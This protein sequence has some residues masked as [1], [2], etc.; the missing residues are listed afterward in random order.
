MGIERI[1]I[2]EENAQG[3]TFLHDTLAANGYDVEA[4]A[5]GDAA[6]SAFMKKDFDLILVSESLPGLSGHRIL[7]RVK[8]LD[9]S[10]PVVLLTNAGSGEGVV[11]ALKAGAEDCFIR[12]FDLERLKMLLKKILHR[13]RILQENDYLRGEFR[14]DEGP[15]VLVGE[16]DP[17]RRAVLTARELADSDE[18]V[19]LKG[20]GGTGKEMLARVIHFEGSRASGPFVKVKCSGLPESL[21][22]SEFFGHERGAFSGAHRKREGRF[23]LAH[24][25]TLVLDGLGDIPVSL[26]AKLLEFLEEGRFHRMGGRRVI[27]VNVRVVGLT[28]RDLAREAEAGSFRRDLYQ[29]IARHSVQLPPLRDRADDV[30]LLVSHFVN[31][32]RQANDSQVRGVS[33]EAMEM[34]SHYAWPGN[35]RELRNLVQRLMVLNAGEE[36]TP[37]QLPPE[38]TGSL[39]GR[40]DPFSALVGMSVHEVER[41]MILKTLEETGN[42]KTAAAKILGLTARTLHNKLKLYREQGIIAKDAYRPIRRRPEPR[43]I[44]AVRQFS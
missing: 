26:Q 40:G 33:P 3:R 1:L 31:R 25:G 27:E 22:E 5:E 2:A 6:L 7:E 32:F 9:A 19:V 10:T 42:N 28:V 16:S 34:L 20:E 21:L 14:A 12:P 41:E 29:R 30:P 24:G 35:I 11:A 37:E 4:H 39:V 8:D 38:V 36:I 43:R 18:P 44:E 23:E 13:R 17:I 15:D